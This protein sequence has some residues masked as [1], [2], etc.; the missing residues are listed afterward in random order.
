M[1]LEARAERGCGRRPSRSAV[2]SSSMVRL[3]LRTQPR[4]GSW[5]ESLDAIFGVH[6][7]HEPRNWSAGL[8][9]GAINLSLVRRSWRS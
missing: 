2:E 5:R 1:N 7:D 9:P 4:S 3:V 8:Q 6:W